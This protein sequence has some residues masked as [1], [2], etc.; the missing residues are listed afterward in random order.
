MARKYYLW[1]NIDFWLAL[2]ERDE[3]QERKGK[4]K[5]DVTIDIATVQIPVVFLNVTGGKKTM[6][7]RMMDAPGQH[8]FVS[9]GF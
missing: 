2:G 4:K 9:L 7:I 8:S 5:Q 6:V 3:G 1:D